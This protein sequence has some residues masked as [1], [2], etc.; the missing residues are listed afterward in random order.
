MNI[1]NLGFVPLQ[2]ANLCLDCETITAAHTNCSAC[3]SGALLNVARALNRPGYPGLPYP[4]ETAVTEIPTKPARPRDFF[5]S[6]GPKVHQRFS[7]ESL[8]DGFQ[9][10]LRNRRVTP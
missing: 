1:S 10:C 5:Q 2:Q 3:G 9:P 6:T 4:E 7:R 8:S